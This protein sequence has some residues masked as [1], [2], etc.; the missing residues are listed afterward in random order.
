[1]H[2]VIRTGTIE[3]EILRNRSMLKKWIVKRIALSRVVSDK[4]MEAS[5]WFHN[6]P[7]DDRSRLIT[8]VARLGIRGV[9]LREI[10]AGPL[11]DLV[12]RYPEVLGQ[13]EMIEDT[14]DEVEEMFDDL[15]LPVGAQA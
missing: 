3:I 9:D 10:A 11:G 4:E 1:V 6:L 13:V 8:D 15:A 7:F 2:H 14:I 5:S 12:R